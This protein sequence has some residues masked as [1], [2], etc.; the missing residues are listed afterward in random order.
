MQCAA[1]PSAAPAGPDVPKYL[2]AQ[3]CSAR[4]PQW[5]QWAAHTP[6][7]GAPLTH[8]LGA[9][10]RQASN[11][12]RALE[13]RPGE[14][15]RGRAA[16]QHLAAS[17]RGGAPNNRPDREPRDP[18]P[19]RAGYLGT[20]VHPHLPYTVIP[21]ISIHSCLLAPCSIYYSTYLSVHT[22]SLI[23]GWVGRREQRLNC[24]PQFSQGWNN[25]LQPV[26]YCQTVTQQP[27][28]I[29]ISTPPAVNQHAARDKWKRNRPSCRLSHNHNTI[30]SASAHFASPWQYCNPHARYPSCNGPASKGSQAST[31]YHILLRY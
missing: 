15:C 28:L 8:L 2:P 26:A 27:T 18:S 21:P 3:L 11:V 14:G 23:F 9:S 30:Y 24:D 20:L 4:W 7:L 31:S 25:T 29:P 6:V 1:Q 22:S 16:S 10:G 19:R 13:L 5:P 17:H 12:W